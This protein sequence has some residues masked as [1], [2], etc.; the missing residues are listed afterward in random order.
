MKIIDRFYLHTRFGGN[1][2]E[3]F[4]LEMWRDNNFNRFW[5]VFNN[6][7]ECKD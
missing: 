1:F 5:R 7:I 6:L 3:L 2:D 4:W